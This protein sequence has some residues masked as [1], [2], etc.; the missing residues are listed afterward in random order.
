VLEV[1]CGTG[2]Y[3]IALRR[4]TGA[5]CAGVDVSRGM[6]TAGRVRAGDV[7][8][9]EGRAEAL[10]FGPEEFDLVFSVDVVHHLDDRP[11][12]FREAARVLR[13]GGRLCVVTDDEA[14]I[15]A[16]LGARYFPETVDAELE[17]YPPLE[18]LRAEVA[19]AGFEATR[20]E[21]CERAHELAET[22]PYR[23]RTH[24]SL[25]L[26]PPRGVRARSRAPRARPPGRADP[27][28]LAGAR[29]PGDEA[30]VATLPGHVQG[31][32][33]LRE[34]AVLR[35]QPEPLDGGDEAPLQPEP[36]ARPRPARREADARLRLHALPQGRQ[37]RESSV[38]NEGNPASRGEV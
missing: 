10:P 14:T 31:L 16:R 6:L 7:E 3:A 23:E 4:A 2:D 5:A 8:L 17:R 24:S 29:A 15:R 30:V 35:E 20:V 38:T 34:E 25:H 26:I 21:R 19:E 32:R 11:A 22:G 33:R 27:R 36:P 28:R 18:T 9:V 37:G 13:P 12:A 1:G